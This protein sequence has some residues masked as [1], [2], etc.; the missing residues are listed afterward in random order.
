MILE[1]EIMDIIMASL[2]GNDTEKVVVVAAWE[3]ELKLEYNN[4]P[5]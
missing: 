1:M 4:Q 2:Q 5:F 3:L